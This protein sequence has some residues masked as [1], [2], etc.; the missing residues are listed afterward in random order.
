MGKL[1]QLNSE[2]KYISISQL[3]KILGISRIA[4]YK[5]VRRGEIEAVRIG[6]S[7]A[8]HQKYI[9]DILNKTLREENKKEIDNAVKKTVKEYGEVLRL[10]GRE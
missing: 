10:L 8:I 1:A 4:V 2:N 9:A 7:F 6:R 5:K 3:A